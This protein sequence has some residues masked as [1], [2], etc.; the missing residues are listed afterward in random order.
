[1]SLCLRQIL[2]R[3]ILAEQMWY[4]HGVENSTYSQNTGIIF[5]TEFYGTQCKRNC[6]DFAESLSQEWAGELAFLSY[7]HEG[8][9]L[10]FHNIE[11]GRVP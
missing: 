6:Q 8:Q 3:Y 11:Y 9:F 5:D 4:R 1:M 2:P 10:A 7:I